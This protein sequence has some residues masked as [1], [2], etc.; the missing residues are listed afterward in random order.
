MT[1]II[2]LSASSQFIDLVPYHSNYPIWLG[3]GDRAPKILQ[4][5]RLYHHSHRESTEDSN[6]VCG[7]V[8]VVVVAM[9]MAMVPSGYSLCV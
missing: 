8:L 2:L 6:Y 9:V 4:P 7:I 5:K 1:E 3:A